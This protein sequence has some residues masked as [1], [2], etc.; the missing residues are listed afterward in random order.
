MVEKPE[1]D[2]LVNTG[3]YI[4]EPDCLKDI[5]ENTSY[6]ITEL[7]NQYIENGEKIGVYPVSENSWLDMGQFTEM[8]NMLEKLGVK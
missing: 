7:I 8:E 1:Y 4:L 2:Y 3:M 6:H 5:P